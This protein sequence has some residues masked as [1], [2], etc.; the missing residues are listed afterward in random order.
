MRLVRYFL[1]FVIVALLYNCA[2]KVAT[3]TASKKHTEDLS[4]YRP[5][6]MPENEVLSDTAMN[7]FIKGAYVK[8]THDINRKLDMALDTLTKL[9]LNRPITAYT[10]QVYTGRSREEANEARQKVYESM[11]DAQPHLEYRQPSFRV[12]V[13]NFYDRVEAYKTFTTLKRAF[14]AAI[15]IQERKYLQQ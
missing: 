4:S 14:P 13:G 15:L 11:P 5:K 9:N 6:V 7:M 3:K 12:K 10:V 8:P 1:F 2:T